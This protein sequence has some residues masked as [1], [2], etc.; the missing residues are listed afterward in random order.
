[1]VVWLGYQCHTEIKDYQNL[2]ASE[3]AAVVWADFIK[4]IQKFRPD[5]LSGSFDRPDGV[6]EVSIDPERGCQSDAAMSIKEFFINGTEPS[7]CR[8]R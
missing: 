5:L 1:M 4:S 6:V 7:P 8:M 3:T 2:F